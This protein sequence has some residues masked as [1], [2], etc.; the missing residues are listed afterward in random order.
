MIPKFEDMKN[1]TFKIVVS[2]HILYVLHKRAML[3]VSNFC[4]WF[5]CISAD[6]R[7]D[8]GPE[9]QLI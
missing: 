8:R 6:G 1:A 5:G 7:G 3:I 9:V 4:M 2:L